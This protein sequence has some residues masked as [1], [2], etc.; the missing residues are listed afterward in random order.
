MRFEV[1]CHLLPGATFDV[2]QPYGLDLFTV[3]SWCSQERYAV[4]EGDCDCPHYTKG[5]VECCKHEA[6]ALAVQRFLFE[7]RR[8]RAQ[9]TYRQ[10]F[11]CEFPSSRP[12]AAA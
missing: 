9:E 12:S 3:K 1:S 8:R 7:E 2:I 4:R 11:G 10:V 6:V 5:E